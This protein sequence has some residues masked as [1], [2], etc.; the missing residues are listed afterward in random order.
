MNKK[1]FGFGFAIT[2]MFSSL[3]FSSFANVAN[4]TSAT[5]TVSNITQTSADI[6][7]T[8]LD[9][10]TPTYN[11][12]VSDIDRSVYYFDKEFSTADDKTL[13]INVNNLLKDGKYLIALFTVNKSGEIGGSEVAEYSFNTK[14]ESVDLNFSALNGLISVANDT[15]DDATKKEGTK[16]GEYPVGSKQLLRDAI[17][18][19][20][21]L[22]YD[23]T[24]ILQTD[25]N[26]GVVRLQYA[27]DTF[28]LSKNTK[29]ISV[30][31][32]DRSKNTGQIVPKC[33]TGA[34]DTA[35]GQYANP[36]NFEYLLT[37]INN[38][39][40]FLLFTIATPFIALILVYA[41]WLYLSSSASPKNIDT[42]KS[43]FKNAIIGYVLALAAWLIVKTIM[44]SL[45]YTGTMYLAF[46]ISKM[47]V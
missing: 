36:C 37:L 39:I 25:I 24:A 11:I 3:I 5:I 9:I 31:T 17:D 22:N 13:S 38:V 21:Y 16:I 45:G 23:P 32:T 12:L 29:D 34:I 27:I 43:I 15:F 35:T 30:D 44:T 7:V 33:N 8:N 42:A 20:E 4:A 41:G 28:E 19:A 10:P 46:I 40:K 6:K 2:L 26:N 47:F 1:L 14:K 18:E